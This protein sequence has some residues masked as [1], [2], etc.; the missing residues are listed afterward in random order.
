MRGADAAGRV[1]YGERVDPAKPQDLSIREFF[2]R[3]KSEQELIIG[4][5]ARSRISDEWVL[6]LAFPLTMPDGGFGGAAYVLINSARLTAAFAAL[7]IGEH[8]AIV[9]L[10]NRKR[11]LHRYP[12]AEDCLL[13]TSP[14]PRD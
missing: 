11:V 6:P 8:G 1:I 9:L 14:S 3:A 4:T 5:P 12:E 7:N 10:D 13:Y 2:Q